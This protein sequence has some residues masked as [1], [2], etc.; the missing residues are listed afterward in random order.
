MYFSTYFDVFSYKID[1]VMDGRRLWRPP[2]IN[3]QFYIKK[4]SKYIEKYVKNM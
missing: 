1:S 4:S 2:L 3:Y